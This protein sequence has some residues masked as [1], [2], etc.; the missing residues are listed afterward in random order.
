[1]KPVLEKYNND[2]R[3]RSLVHNLRALVDQNR[4]DGFSPLDIVEAAMVMYC[5]YEVDVFKKG[6]DILL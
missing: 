6:R 2:P 5:Y 1:M 4:S 3:F